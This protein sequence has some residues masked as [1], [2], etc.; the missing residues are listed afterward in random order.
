MQIKRYLPIF[1]LLGFILVIV[2]NYLA[3]SLPLAGRKTGEISDMYPNLFAPAGFTFSIWGIIYLL[4][5]AFII[6]QIKNTGKKDQPDYLNKTGWLFIISCF[7]NAS[8]LFAWHN[9]KLGLALVI[10]LVILGSLTAIYL[11]LNIGKVEISTKE[12]LLVHV[13]FSVY[14]GWI[15]VATIANTTIFFVSLGWEGNPFNPQFWTVLVIIAAIAINLLAI[16]KRKDYAFGLAG[17]WALYGIYAKRAATD[18][19]ILNGSVEIIAVTGILVLLIS[20]FLQIFIK[21]K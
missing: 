21:R 8:W 13:P 12:K 1:N 19:S 20:I 6:F 11:K 5:A 4:L 9:L 14:L 15:T 16:Y 3:V 18:T 10:M 7:A 17:T 2:M